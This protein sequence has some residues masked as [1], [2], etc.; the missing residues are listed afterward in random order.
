MREVLYTFAQSSF[1]THAFCLKSD[2]SKAFDIM[3]WNFIEKALKV[4][5]L[6]SN[7]TK[8]VM[9]CI[10]SACY[11]IFF[12]MAGIGFTTPVRGLRQGCALSPYVFIICMN[13]LTSMLE[14][15]LR[16][17][18][19][20][21]LKLAHSAPPITNILYANDLLLMGNA[22]RNEARQ[23]HATLNSFCLLSS[24]Q[25]SPEKSKLW[26]SKSTP[27]TRIRSVIRIFK[28]GFADNSELNLGGP[29]DVSRPLAFANLLQKI[30]NRLHVWKSI[31]LTPAGKIVLLKAVMESLCIYHMS[32]TQ[33]HNWSWIRS[34]QSVCNF[35]GEK[36]IKRQYA[37][38]N[39][40]FLQHRNW[41][42]A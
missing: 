33:I 20:R 7:F 3:S 34:N 42:E 13:I 30:D 9:A 2:L 28:V 37:L 36:R 29:I 11:T 40:A 8:W 23:I 32:T 25:I 19:L 16:A 21:G 6:P 39:G 12:E 15:E 14:R 31:L 26:F 5:S 38:W 24:Q 4:Q 18:N 10:R 27:L 22:D 1:R 41:K 35:S 17:Q